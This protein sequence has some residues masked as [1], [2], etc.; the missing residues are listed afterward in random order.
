MCAAA[1][2]AD[3][4]HASR[5]GSGHAHVLLFA[6]RARQLL[7]VWPLHASVPLY[8]LAA[9]FLLWPP[10]KE[11]THC[12]SGSA[13][14]PRAHLA[15]LLLAGQ[16]GDLDVGVQRRQPHYLGARV[17]RRAEHRD[18]A[19][20]LAPGSGT[21]A[22][23]PVRAGPSRGGRRSACCAL[24]TTSVSRLADASKPRMVCQGCCAQPNGGARAT[25]AA[26]KVILVERTQR[27]ARR[28]RHM[29]R[30]C[31]CEPGCGALQ[32]GGRL[33]A[34]ALQTILRPTRGRTA[35][36]WDAAAVLVAVD[37]MAEE[38][39]CNF[40]REMEVQIHTASNTFR[41]WPCEKGSAK[42]LPTWCGSGE[43][44]GCT[45][46]QKHSLINIHRTVYS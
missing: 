12:A 15:G 8:A 17:A 4:A 34:D 1:A 40:S 38:H 30:D 16:R 3:K 36:R 32:H 23:V 41:P 21:R 24:A 5:T 10:R 28:G 39:A 14:P 29:R 42:G 2:C 45:L 27:G 13:C 43:Y 6:P 7:R 31:R 9:R 25:A 22:R 33:T 11:A 19:G 20:V 46:R 26:H 44:D 37:C 35:A 18:A